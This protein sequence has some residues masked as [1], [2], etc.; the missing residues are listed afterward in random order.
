[1]TRSFDPAD[2]LGAVRRSLGTTDQDGT[3]VRVLTVE[4]SYAASPTEVWEALTTPER[5]PR[6]FMPISGDLRE[7]GRFHLE[8][9]ASGDILACEPPHR[10]RTTWEYG[11]ELSWVDLTL[12]ADGDHTLL[13]LHHTAP[14]DPAKWAEYGPG[15]VGIGWEMGLL[16]LAMHLAAPEAPRPDPADPAMAAA[17][18]AYMP[19]S[20]DAWAEASITAG[21]DPEEAH[22]AAARCLAAYTGQG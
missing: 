17:L 11:G 9:N 22:A 1:M 16:G 8:G 10:L 18:A 20:S 13:L 14:V 5:I 21:T 7:G 12:S 3:E 4:R 19:A 6:W 15:A 2:H